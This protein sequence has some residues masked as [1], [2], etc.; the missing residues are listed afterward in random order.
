MWPKDHHDCAHGMVQN[1]RGSGGCMIGNGQHIRA[2]SWR[3][4]YGSPGAARRLRQSLL[5]GAILVVAPAAASA[6]N[7]IVNGGFETGTDPAAPPWVF[8]NGAIAETNPP[9][10]HT[11][12]RFLLLACPF[13]GGCDL[14]NLPAFNG[15]ASQT[16]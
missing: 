16:V 15:T 3:G 6:Q 7:F 12:N 14:L 9:F 2:P 4:R 10:A 5:A 1:C 8:T 13:V 11:G